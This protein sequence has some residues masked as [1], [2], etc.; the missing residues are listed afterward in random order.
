MEVG[1][2]I[3]LFDRL[4]DVLGLVKAGEIEKNDRVDEA[5]LKT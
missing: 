1:V 5:P 4:L 2:A 3:G